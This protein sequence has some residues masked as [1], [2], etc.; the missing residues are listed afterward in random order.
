MSQDVLGTVKAFVAGE[1][2]PAQ[3]RDRLYSDEGFEAF[4]ATDPHLRPGNYAHPSVYHFLLEQDLDDPGGVL[5]AQG[6]LV[7]YM[8]RNGIP[9]V[10]TPQYEDLY[11]LILEAQPDWL[12][13]DSRYVQDHILPH[14]GGRK[15]EE[16]REWLKNEFLE[17]FRCA[18]E[19]PDWIQSPAWP[20]G[21]NGPLVFLGQLDINH[22]FHDYATAYVFYDPASG[23]CETVLQA[24]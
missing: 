12:D 22:Y 16:L 11:N 10:R 4:L 23:K 15:G 5:S 8:D 24:F 3:F 2:S 19:S 6:A 13:V 21:E 17:R 7:D 9:Y 14:A 18:A 1:M 20:I